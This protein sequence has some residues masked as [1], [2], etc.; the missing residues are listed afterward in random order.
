MKNTL[1]AGLAVGAAAAVAGG[2]FVTGASASSTIP[3]VPDGS[4]ASS[5][6]ASKLSP[7]P[8][9]FAVVNADGTLARGKGVTSVT[10][11]GTG[12][13]DV[14][15][16]RNIG[17]C[18]WEGTVGFGQFSGSTGPAQI[19]ITGRAGTTNGLFVTTFNATGASTDEPFHALVVCS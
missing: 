16:S 3:N 9:V 13:Y 7:P 11:I 17:T 10:K 4:S 8:R 1:K 14:R 12:T 5:A 19:T 2:L 6:P 18:T 15:F